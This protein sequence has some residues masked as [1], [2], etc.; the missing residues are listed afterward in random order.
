MNWQRDRRRRS[1]RLS[2]VRGRRLRIE[3]LE[4]RLFLAGDTYL[5]NFQLAG[6]PVPTRYLADTGQVFGDRGGGLFYGWSSDHTDVSRDRGIN[7][8]QRLDT[9]IHFHQNQKWEFALPNGLYAVTVSIGDAEHPST[10]TLNVEGVNYWNAVALTPNSF[11]NATQQV[12]VSDGRLTLNQGAAIEK[13]TR[14]N[15]VHV[16]GLPSGP[17]AT[18]AAPTITEPSVNAAPLN[19][20]DVHMEAV[21]FTDPDGNLHKSTDWEIWTVGPSAEPV[22]QTL[23]ITGVERLHTHLGDGVFINSHAG[24]TDLIADSVPNFDFNTY[25]L[26]ILGVTAGDHLTIVAEMID[27]T[28]GIG[29]SLSGMVDA[30]SL[31][32]PTSQNLINDGSFELATSGSQTSN[33]NWVMTAQSDGVEP[34]AQFQTAT[35]AASSGSKGVWFKGFRGNAGNPVDASVSQV[36]TATVSGDYT[37]LFDAKVEEFF[38]DVIGGFRVTITS[39]GTG[40][41]RMINVLDSLNREYELRVRYRDDA[42]AVSSYATRRFHVGAASTVFPMELSDVR[43]VPSPEWLNAVGG[44][45]VL[46]SS[47]PNQ[48]ELR[49]EAAAGNLLLSIAAGGSPH[50]ITNP[51]PLADHADLRVVVQAGSSGLSLGPSEL[52]FQDD[53]AQEHTVYLPAINLAANQR[54]DLWVASEGSTYYGSAAQT[55]PDFSDLARRADLAV[56][57]LAMQPGFVVEAV[58]D[59][60]Q[61]PTNIAFVPNPGPDPDDPLFYVTE[62]YGTIKVVTNDFTV[63]DYATGLLNFNPTGAFPGSGEQGLTG[64][65]VDPVTGDVFATRVTAT[66]PADPNSVHHPQ[67]LRFLSNDG[68]RTAAGPPTV[69]RN[70]V[71]ENQGQS[72]QISNVTLGPDGKLYVHMGDGFDYTTAQNLDSYRGKVLR[73][74]LD[75]SAPSDNPFYSAANGINARD[76]VY[77][78][79]LRNPFGGAWRAADG[80][81]YQVENGPSVDRFSQINRGVNYGWNNTDASM[82]INAIYNW[83]PAHAPVNISFVQPATFGGS[84]FPA[85]MQDL[86]FVSESGPTYATGPQTRGKRIVQFA[87]NTSGGLVSGP[88]TLV[89]Y[90]GIGKGTVV[91]LAAG[92]DGLYFTELYKDLDAVTPIDAGARVFR[93]RYANPLA[94]DYDINGIVDQ[95]DYGVWTDNFGSQILGAA[96]GNRN[97]TVDAADYV[98]WRK[99]QGASL[100]DG[101]GGGNGQISNDQNVALA[102]PT[103]IS[104]TPVDV[105]EPDSPASVTT[106]SASLEYD[107]YI[108]NRSAFDAPA[109]VF[110]RRNATAQPRKRFDVSE[111]VKYSDERLA[112]LLAIDRAGRPSR[113]DDSIVGHEP[114]D[115][116]QGPYTFDESLLVAL[117]EWR[118]IKGVAGLARV[119]QPRAI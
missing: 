31:F 107:S 118:W 52:T 113:R 16:V 12:T 68:G 119:Q 13:A 117:A 73:M 5:L 91:G 105:V 90:V 98:L 8:D 108:G 74:N 61:L 64:I 15:Y 67:V 20:G 78:F 41:S 103:S 18:P 35:W 80:K 83:N 38:P 33:S 94:G 28:G 36:V 93:V 30:F 97:G 95:N 62:L 34:A 51:S 70:M 40:G 111:S 21:G 39:D 109:S 1:P 77:A 96:D 57:F 56:P 88:T 50:V 9:L 11:L 10:H 4:P 58:A 86:A 43:D 25:T 76:Y 106:A 92:P 54:L 6:S 89:E 82:T 23:G 101:A 79:G 63:S 32:S 27:A 17:N 110:A 99:M 85:S 84:E 37:L 26:T 55:E 112:L 14:I 115:D 60:L 72:H 48:S 2:A 49:L 22:W 53:R 71:G 102:S 29:P 19:P 81:H 7:A 75:G 104:F 114:S 69:I 3:A 116:P 42:G 46:P 66:N 45:I 47:E 100:P 44:N 87:L 59:G 24:R 65:A